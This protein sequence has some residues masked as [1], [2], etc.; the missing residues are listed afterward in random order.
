MFLTSFSGIFRRKAGGTQPPR[1]SQP[2][3]KCSE[4][5][6]GGFSRAAPVRAVVILRPKPQNIFSGVI[7]IGNT[8]GIGEM[9]GGPFPAPPGAVPAQCATI[10][11]AFPSGP[12]RT[13][14]ERPG[15]E[16][17]GPAGPSPGRPGSAVGPRPS[18][19]NAGN[20]GLKV[21]LGRK[22]YRRT[23]HFDIEVAGSLKIVYMRND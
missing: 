17:S 7:L 9:P 16:R 15:P 14:P 2:S 19:G 6:R 1:T 3:P 18:A 4:A 11:F 5:S 21:T 20:N 12:E 23:R 8:Q 10:P 13:G 22:R